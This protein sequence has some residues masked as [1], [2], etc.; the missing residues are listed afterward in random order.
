MHYTDSIGRWISPEGHPVPPFRSSC[1]GREDCRSWLLLCR[2]V[3]FGILGC[4]A[5]SL[6]HSSRCSHGGV[7]GALRS[8]RSS[9]CPWGP[10]DGLHDVLRSLC[11][12]SGGIADL[13]AYSRA[14]PCSFLDLFCRLR[15]LACSSCG[16]ATAP[17]RL[18]AY[19]QG[20]YS[21]CTCCTGCSSTW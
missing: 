14:S 12:C 7:H 10:R 16:T 6:L 2:P 13:L 3:L 5:A 18:R 9:R 4:S 8:S 1:G 17:G 19:L 21:C 20:R 11:S 15:A